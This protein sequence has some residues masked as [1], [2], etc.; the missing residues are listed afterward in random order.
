[1][2]KAKK[3]QSRKNPT[4][5]QPSRKA[6][7]GTVKLRG[8]K[9]KASKKSVNKKV[10][11]ASKKITQRRKKKDV[12]PEIIFD[13]RVGNT[14]ALFVAEPELKIDA[15]VDEALKEFDNLPSVSAPV[16]AT[17]PLAGEAISN[18]DEGIASSQ[19]PRNDVVKK[20]KAWWQKLFGK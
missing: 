4:S 1:M 9:P 7:A 5:P 15:A 18:S 11:A 8:T 17:P 2:T 6:S 19:T 12:S 3:K 20:K 16:I 10:S 14:D 13:S